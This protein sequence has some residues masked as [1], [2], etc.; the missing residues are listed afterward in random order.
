MNLD[1]IITG[2]TGMIGKGCLLLESGDINVEGNNIIDCIDGSIP[3][4]SKGGIERKINW[5]FHRR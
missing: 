5:E 3:L 2:S 4:P 1:V